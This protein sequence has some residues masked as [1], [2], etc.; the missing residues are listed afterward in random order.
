MWPR[1]SFPH[2]P[3]HPSPPCLA[4]LLRPYRRSTRLP[5]R[6][7]VGCLVSCSRSRILCVLEK[8]AGPAQSSLTDSASHFH[9]YGVRPCHATR[10]LKIRSWVMTCADSNSRRRLR[11]ISDRLCRNLRPRAEARLPGELSLRRGLVIGT[12]SR[13]PAPPC[14]RRATRPSGEWRYTARCHNECPAAVLPDKALHLPCFVAL[15]LSLS[16]SLSLFSRFLSLF[17]VVFSLRAC[18]YSTFIYVLLHVVDLPRPCADTH[19]HTM[20]TSNTA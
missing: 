14:A 5:A 19:K 13:M 12:D 4:F 10:L 11:L 17:C 6:M 20:H 16:L 7:L 2:R 15:S 8:S 1:R 3:R 18:V 9:R